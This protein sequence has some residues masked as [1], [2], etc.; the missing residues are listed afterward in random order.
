MIRVIENF[1]ALA[2]HFLF[3]FVARNVFLRFG[4]T[5]QTTTLTL[6]KSMVSMSH[7][8]LRQTWDKVGQTL[9][10]TVYAPAPLAISV[11]YL[12]VQ[13]AVHDDSEPIPIASSMPSS[14]R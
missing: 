4:G 9:F 5:G 2:G 7:I 3:A 6:M 13:Q 11:G 8:P 12:P 14:E 1:V 10:G